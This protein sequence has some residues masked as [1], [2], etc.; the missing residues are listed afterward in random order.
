MVSTHFGR[1]LLDRLLGRFVWY[2]LSLAKLQRSLGDD[3]GAFRTLMASQQRG[4]E[5][6]RLHLE[7]SKLYRDDG[8][9][10]DALAHLRIAEE[11]KPGESSIRRLTLESDHDLHDAGSKTLDRVLSLPARTIH[12][13]ISNLNRVSIFYPEHRARLNAVR[14]RLLTHLESTD[15]SQASRAS[16]AVATALSCLQLGMAMDIAARSDAAGNKLR[17]NTLKLLT[18]ITGDLGRHRQFLDAA[19][20]N[21]TGDVLSAFSGG[22]RRLLSELGTDPDRIVEIFIPRAFFSRPEKEMPSYQTI[23][24]TFVHII[25]YLLSRADLVVVPRL[26]MHVMRCVPKTKGGRVVSYHTK[27]HGNPRHLHVQETPLAG[28][29]SFDHAG[30]AGYASI[31]TDFD[32]VRAATAEVGKDVLAANQAE[33]YECYAL[34][35]VSKYHQTAENAPLPSPYV[36]VALQIPTDTVAHLAFMNGTE[37]LESVV[38]FYRGT[39]TKVVVKRH[40]YCGSMGVQKCLDALEAAGDIIRT[41]NSIHSVISNAQIIFTVNSGVGLEALMHGKPVVVSGGCDY[42]FAV[43]TVKNRDELY[44]V[45]SKGVIP[46]P[47]RIQQL[48]YYYTRHFTVSASDE[49][50]VHARLDAWLGTHV[51]H[52]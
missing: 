30:F 31:A 19:W 35:N 28:R 5:D 25:D 14:E 32:Q 23:R 52:C 27:G 13:H 39:G 34:K 11:L 18:R 7:L 24:Q 10:M 29:S 45:L 4:I 21:E 47:R 49:T 51:Q 26:L 38:G 3:L 37:L 1:K 12:S 43:T 15:V 44:A 2:Y 33:M 40:P 20:D 6:D 41:S 16:E 17:P 8:Q 46:D 9:V 48:L 22:Q 42:S 36:F 50:A